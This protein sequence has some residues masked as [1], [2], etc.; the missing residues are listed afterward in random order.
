MSRITP[1]EI[2]NSKTLTELNAGKGK[3]LDEKFQVRTMGR[4]WR[5]CMHYA[6]RLFMPRK[7]K[8]A[9]RRLYKSLSS[10][11]I[12]HKPMGFKRAA[13][14]LAKAEL[15]DIVQKGQR[16]DIKPKALLD[17]ERLDT[18]INSSDKSD[19]VLMDELSSSLPSKLLGQKRKRS[20]SLSRME[21]I[22]G[23]TPAKHAKT[24]PPNSGPVARP[25]LNNIE[26]IP[27][28]TS[29]EERKI[30]K[31][32]LV[33]T[34]S[35][36]NP[37][38]TLSPPKV[39]NP[40]LI[41]VPQRKPEEITP[42]YQQV[43]SQTDEA[44]RYEDKL[45]NRVNGRYCQNREQYAVLRNA[46]FALNDFEK[47]LN[48][49]DFVTLVTNG[50]LYEFNEDLLLSWEDDHYRREAADM[51]VKLGKRPAPAISPSTLTSP[52]APIAKKAV[53]YAHWCRRENSFSP[54]VYALRVTKSDTCIEEGFIKG[55]LTTFIADKLQSDFNMTIDES[56]H[57]A[58]ALLQALNLNPGD[59]KT[60]T[61]GQIS[62][63]AARIKVVGDKH[64]E[65][66]PKITVKQPPAS[67][68][69]S[70][71][72]QNIQNSPEH[73]RVYEQVRKTKLAD[74]AEFIALYEALDPRVLT[75]DLFPYQ[76]AVYNWLKSS[77]EFS[78]DDF[79]K[80][81]Q[82]GLLNSG[83]T[84]QLLKARDAKER[85][86]NWS[87]K[88]KDS[89]YSPPK[90]RA[91]TSSPAMGTQVNQPGTRAQSRT[92]EHINTVEM[93]P[94][95]APSPLSKLPSI[96]YL[97]NRK[98]MPNFGCTCY[99][100]SVC[101]QLS[102]AI[103]PD[104][105]EELATKPIPDK[106]ASNIRDEFIKTTA[107]IND[108]YPGIQTRQQDEALKQRFKSAQTRLLNACYEH[109][110]HVPGSRFRATLPH[111]RLE[112]LD[113]E[114]ASEFFV[115]ISDALKL[116][117]HLSSSLQEADH[118]TLK[119]AGQSYTC[120]KEPNIA[121]TLLQVK[122]P[123]DAEEGKMNWQNCVYA[124]KD[125]MPLKREWSEDEAGKAGYPNPAALHKQRRHSSRDIVK[126]SADISQI[127]SLTFHS[128]LTDGY[129]DEQT[130]RYTNRKLT[131]R[132]RRVL[133]DGTTRLKQQVYDLKTGKT[134]EVDLNLQ[135]VVVHQGNSLTS[136]HYT[137]LVRSQ[138]GPWV[139]FNDSQPVIEYPSLNAYLAEDKFRTP[140]LLNY[141]VTESVR[142]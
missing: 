69:A 129:Y 53:P 4:F 89:F 32:T 9:V 62:S 91:A 15:V 44:S 123:D 101:Q 13:L 112:H 95:A 23:P 120:K 97:L 105:M 116:N 74:K 37:L 16:L 122:L 141:K 57:T 117:D 25:P 127:R 29:P 104:T 39:V 142:P 77:G 85:P 28:P 11:K 34:R 124:M 82:Q 1:S 22:A 139:L 80:C 140:Y 26:N 100:N 52:P 55:A 93:R 65:Q 121:D 7:N 46:F 70:E 49:E 48:D 81:I 135:S 98:G 109:G 92:R 33:R 21:S 50:A 125:T 75:N 24:D 118:I 40:P 20:S 103:P 99:F 115:A 58:R 17:K 106:Y 88:V 59:E 73:A 84:T 64:L 36:T 31:P 134:V 119:E 78:R 56:V 60:V 136:G 12:G 108:E 94:E 19:D 110:Q 72:P 132:G 79:V 18:V 8:T 130:Q 87:R 3:W 128:N 61:Y 30:L 71:L 96:D 35:Q 90:A 137:T 133:A 63:I 86:E 114:D 14:L 113:Q 66:R 51:M 138:E 107:L 6:P 67:K 43:A 5:L 111:N 76:L 47:A 102:L 2:I 41:P 45:F 38:K 27:R 83:I 126:V 54:L 10:Y 131:E 42:I 68:L